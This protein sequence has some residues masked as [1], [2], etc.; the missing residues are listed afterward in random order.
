MRI[1]R[2][3]VLLLSVLF[4]SSFIYAYAYA[5][6]IPERAGMVTDAAG[7][8]TA[9]QAKQLGESLQGRSYEMVVVTAKGLNE[10]AVQ[11]FG[12]DAYN[13]WK[14]GRN[15]L[16]LVVTAE[17]DSAHLVYDNEQVANAVSQSE[18][19]NTKGVIDLNYTPL[20]AKGNRAAGIVAV[21][22]YVNALQVP[23]P[24]GPTAPSSPTGAVGAIENP[25]PTVP[26]VP[27]VDGAAGSATPKAPAPTGETP[28]PTASTGSA[29]ADGTAPMT[30]TTR[31]DA[32]PL[33]QMTIIMIAPIILLVFIGLFMVRRSLL[34]SRTREVLN[35]ARKLYKEADFTINKWAAE[36]TSEPD[37][38]IKQ[39][40]AD[41]EQLREQLNMNHVSFLSKALNQQEVESLYNEVQ[42]FVQRVELHEELAAADGTVGLQE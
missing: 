35:E 5:A 25:T 34:L 36:P 9:A 10:S 29:N 7:L 15:Q 19:G 1:W 3:L 37:E 21:S 8:F 23:L 18:A 12:N 38:V 20:A 39:L 11:Q 42:V 16:L 31:D 22:N 28:I 24:T 4:F 6:S 30:T 14:L 41:S 27:P 33:S 17:P 13:A 2:L 26:T 40:Q 32:Y